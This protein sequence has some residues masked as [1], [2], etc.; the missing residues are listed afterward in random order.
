LYAT[1]LLRAL[2]ATVSSSAGVEGQANAMGQPV[3]AAPSVFSYFSPFYMVAGNAPPPVP[4]PEFQIMNATTALAR[5]NFAYRV[6]TNGIS[7]TV[8]VDLTNLQDLAANP[9]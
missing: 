4:A 3:L 2:N 9:P 5:A 8:Q 7:S 1:Q 6:A